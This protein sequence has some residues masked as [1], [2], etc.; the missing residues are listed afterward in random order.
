MAV[1]VRTYQKT[2][3]N[4][5]LVDETANLDDHIHIKERRL[6]EAH[7]IQSISQSGLL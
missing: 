4:D 2:K 7:Q 3:E 1:T 5:L 6:R